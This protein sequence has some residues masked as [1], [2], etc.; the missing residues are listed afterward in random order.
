M[1]SPLPLPWLVLPVLALVTSAA[2][3]GAQ[4]PINGVPLC[5]A[6]GGQ[7]SPMIVADGTGG[8][9][10]TWFDARTGYYDIYAQHVLATGAVD[11]A[12]PVDGRALCTAADHQVYPKIVADGAGGAIV[13]W[14][15]DRS[16]G[17]GDIYAHHVLASG[18]LDPAWPVNGLAVCTAANN[19]H[20]PTIV[21]DG[22]G[23]A[24]VTWYD[25]RNGNYDIY[26]Q[27]VLG[28]GAVDA[29]WPAD[30]QALCTA[31]NDQS[32]PT[33]VAD[34]AGGAIVTWQDFRG[35]VNNDIYAQ[36][37]LGSGAVDTAWP[38]DGRALCTATDN[39]FNATI[40][41]D[42]A[43]GAIVTW[44]DRRAGSF[45]IYAQ[46]VLGSGAV[47]PAWPADGRA[48][49]T[50]ANNQSAPT[51]VADGAGGAIVTWE[52]LRGGGSADI[53]TQHVLASGAVDPA[54]PADG[55]ALCIAANDQNHPTIVSDG[56]G[57]AIV[58]WD[59]S[60][61]GSANIDIY[62]QHVLGSGAVDPSWPVDGRA[63]CTAAE[64]QIVPTIVGDGAGGAI[65]T[66]EDHRN[67]TDYDIYAQRVHASGEVAGVPLPAVSKRFGLLP[68]H[69]NPS[70]NGS[71]T[72]R[73]DLPSSGHV[74]A[75]VFD[76][77]GHLV[78]TLALERQ[79]QAGRQAIE[80]DGRNE[81]RTRV[82]GGIYFVRVRVGA[83]FDV[84][85]M[86]R[87]E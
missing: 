48:L 53:Y 86:V 17:I 42:Q 38:V 21:A 28:S 74:S 47:D 87:L 11:P 55:R 64:Y 60:R 77:T 51:I 85:R 25:A 66:W 15:D 62:A 16:G 79:F 13:A 36:H 65:V 49:C 14:E 72:I 18:A 81:I 37:V 35:G 52:D 54:W 33:I 45:D 31:A 80:W 8:A 82:P 46:H 68:P 34:G 58:T 32:L 4:W 12:W 41:A 63:L 83:Y 7:A 50:A 26:A 2:P 29:A 76:V 59:D 6:T 40:V 78:R 71:I 20:L 61:G 9:I 27:H 10:V 57:G 3:A 70:V 56:A 73:F 19:Q 23:G 67:G 69:P 30:G 39:Q 84:G 75:Q 43:G 24:I 1:R 22:A 5:T 44:Q